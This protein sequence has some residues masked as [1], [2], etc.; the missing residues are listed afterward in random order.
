MHLKSALMTLLVFRGFFFNYRLRGLDSPNTRK[1]FESFDS[2]KDKK[3]TPI[4]VESL[5]PTGRWEAFSGENVTYDLRIWESKELNSVV[6]EVVYEREGLTENVH[7]LEEALEPDTV[8]TWSV[9]ARFV[10]DGKVRV[11]EWSK[12]KISS[13]VLLQILS[14]GLMAIAETMTEW[15]FYQFRTP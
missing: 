6:G 11:T 2:R 5:R 13:T 10:E 15:G 4:R 12:Y 1:Q 3:W 14:L 8:Y 7:T 9:R